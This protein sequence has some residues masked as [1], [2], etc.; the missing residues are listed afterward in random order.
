MTDVDPLL[1]EFADAMLDERHEDAER[2]ATEVAAE[3]DGTGEERSAIA[4]STAARDFTTG[5]VDAGAIDGET[6]DTDAIDALHGH[7]TTGLTTQ[8][9]RLKV[10]A[11]LGAMAADPESVSD[12]EVEES[13]DGLRTELETSTAT[14]AEDAE[15]ARAVRDE[16]VLGPHATIRSVESGSGT[17]TVATGEPVEIVVT[18]EN[19]GDEP[20]TDVSVDATV[21]ADVDVDSESD[22]VGTLEAGQSHTTS[23]TVQL[24]ASAD[25]TE[26]VE[27]SLESADA[28]TDSQRLVLV[29]E[30]E[31]ETETEAE[32][33][34]PRF[35]GV[36]VERILAG[37]AV[38]A[39][40]LY[41]AIKLRA[42]EAE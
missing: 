37:G 24:A 14:L 4:R 5:E 7:V 22:T 20:G 29:R 41:L 17:R 1:E 38:T 9:S 23:F 16:I 30:A 33:S 8:L 19:V 11:T 32:E 2:I 27:V 15:T 18:V 35:A 3:L 40:M 13:I 25:R 28:G 34:G 12:Q 6:I 10:L 26:A 39:G 42:G 31:A 36:P 21:S